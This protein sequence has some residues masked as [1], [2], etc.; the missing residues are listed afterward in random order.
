M[1]TLGQ[2]ESLFKSRYRNLREGLLYLQTIIHSEKNIE[3]R[4]NIDVR[5]FIGE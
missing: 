1:F 4:I 2:M 5:K 3:Y